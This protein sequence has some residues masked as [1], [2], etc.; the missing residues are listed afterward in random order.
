MGVSSNL[1]RLSLPLGLAVVLALVAAPSASA[2]IGI[3]DASQNIVA[4][5]SK[6]NCKVAAGDNGKKRFVVSGKSNGWKL[7]IALNKFDGYRKYK[8]TYGDLVNQANATTPGNIHYYTSF[9]PDGQNGGFVNF[10]K[11]KKG[12]PDKTKLEITTVAYAASGYTVAIVGSAKCVYPK[13]R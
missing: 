1:R 10:G 8:I 5:Y 6:V 9:G 12:K 7:D 4:E 11:G 2:T 3:V 13:K